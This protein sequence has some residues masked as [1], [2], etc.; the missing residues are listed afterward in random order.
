MTEAEKEQFELWWNQIGK[1]LWEEPHS[2]PKD[3]AVSAWSR[4]RVKAK[5][6][7]VEC[8][9]VDGGFHSGSTM[10]MLSI[11]VRIWCKDFP[12]GTKF[13]VTCEEV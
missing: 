5:P 7:V 8:Y 9:K 1:P 11:Q 4:E 2:C 13:R 3:L 12:D 10:N 6:L